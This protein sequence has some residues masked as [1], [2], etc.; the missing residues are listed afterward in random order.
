MEVVEANPAREKT[1]WGLSLTGPALRALAE[2]ELADACLAEGHGMSAITHV[3]VRGEATDRVELPRLLGARRPAMVG[4]ACPALHRVLYAA[5]GRSGAVVRHGL[6]A[7]ALE[8]G[9]AS[10]RVRLSDATEREVTLAVGA[11]GLRSS[12]RG[13]LGLRSKPGY[14]GQMAWR[15]LVP[16]PS[17]GTG[18][19]QFSGKV[20]T[21]G[22]V[23]L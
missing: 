11:D 9:A 2:L 20:H 19:H 17:W 21:A 22:L 4:I 1:G 3:N 18:I 23:R 6:T 14:H 12:V 16:R 8:Q 13:L 15:A 10:V 7:A 5:A